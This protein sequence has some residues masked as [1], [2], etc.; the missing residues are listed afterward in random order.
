MS[1]DNRIQLRCKECGTDIIVGAVSLMSVEKLTKMA[2][3]TECP[4]C[5]AEPKK[6]YLRAD[7]KEEA[8]HD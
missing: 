4:A 8:P 3:E 1:D 7:V 5:G 2:L 6:M